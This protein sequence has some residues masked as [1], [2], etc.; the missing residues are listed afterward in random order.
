[1]TESYL[2]HTI[3]TTMKRRLR[4]K[5]EINELLKQTPSAYATI[6]DLP[7]ELVEK[8]VEDLDDNGS[9]RRL[10]LTCKR[11]HF[12]VLPMFFS[13]NKLE[14]LQNGFFHC[15]YPVPELLEAIRTALFVRNLSTFTFYFTSRF[16]QVIS[17]ISS[18]RGL[19]AR[20]PPVGKILLG[21][22]VYIQSTYGPPGVRS[23]VER[24]GREFL[25]LLETIAESGCKDLTLLDPTSYL[26]DN[27]TPNNLYVTTPPPAKPRGTKSTRGTRNSGGFRAHPH[28]TGMLTIQILSPRLFQ[29]FFIG[30]IINMLEVNRESLVCIHLNVTSISPVLLSQISESMN[31]PVVKE[32]EISSHFNL[33]WVGLCSFLNRHPSITSV[34]LDKILPVKDPQIPDPPIMLPYLTQLTAMPPIVTL[35]LQHR[36]MVP[37]LSSVHVLLNWPWNAQSEFDPLPAIAT[38]AHISSLQLS[39]GLHGDICSILERHIRED[40]CSR[41]ITSLGHIRSVVLDQ[42]NSY[43]YP[44]LLTIKSWLYLFPHLQHV[45]L[46]FRLLD[47]RLD[48]SDEE[49]HD[50]V[51]EFATQLAADRPMMKTLSAGFSLAVNLDDL[52]RMPGFKV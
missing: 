26:S 39:N 3:T 25:K 12:L 35:L 16:D 24:W 9:M 15:L 4:R 49:M 22:P 19:L 31:L 42:A 8:I 1:M 50:V 45:S 46:S 6:T 18:L 7:D 44:S 10:S 32:V 27:L 28:L 47:A 21:L 40:K 29:P 48:L 30:W 2:K 23:T 33:V 13:R 43:S 37:L 41:I 5:V 51:T 17:D 20:I 34:R 36:N 14:N 11:L 38:H 52:R